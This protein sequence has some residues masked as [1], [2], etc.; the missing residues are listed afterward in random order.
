M[1]AAALALSGC[2]PMVTHPPRTDPGVHLGWTGGLD[3]PSDSAV[4]LAMTP[5]AAT[6]LRV[7]DRLGGGW[8]ISGTLAASLGARGGV[9]GDLY[10][11]VPSR[12]PGW[13]H[14][15]GVVAAGNYLMP[16]LQVGRQDSTGSGW[17]TT[18]GYAWRGFQE[19]S[20]DLFGASDDVRPRYWTSTL[21][22]RRQGRRGAREA[23]LSAAVGSFDTRRY[24]YGGERT[25]TAL[26]S[27]A[28]WA[29][30][31]GVSV[32]AN[33]GRLLRAAPPPRYPPRRPPTP[34]PR[35]PPPV[36]LP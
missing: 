8:G 26:V 27:Q 5:M 9:H 20:A 7:A 11:E 31:L 22:A 34:D 17:Y 23:Y 10:A 21:T 16:Y 32:E 24:E 15:A 1:L 13:A 18:H 2:A 19:A 14:G 6:Y 33:L 36:P 4:R 35:V 12:S 30:S 29:V 28:L 3:L 25:D